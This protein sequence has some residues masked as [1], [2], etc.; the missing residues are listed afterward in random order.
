MGEGEW[1]GE[2]VLYVR[3]CVNVFVWSCVCVC[4]FLA[5][6][7]PT[8][9]S[10]VIKAEEEKVRYYYCMHDTDLMLLYMQELL[11]AVQRCI[12]TYSETT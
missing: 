3:L 5:H 6:W 11:Q 9:V 12:F 8:H 10:G 4:E 2:A 7:G 1:I